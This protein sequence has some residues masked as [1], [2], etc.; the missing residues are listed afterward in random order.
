MKHS[1]KAEH[2][3]KSDQKGK[4]KN[5]YDSLKVRI[6]FFPSL[7][8]RPHGRRKLLPCGLGTRLLLP[9]RIVTLSSLVLITYCMA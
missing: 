1:M 7:I 6:T 5:Y 9:S 8:P 4:M 3:M 2:S